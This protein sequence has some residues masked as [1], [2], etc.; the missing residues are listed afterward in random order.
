MTS[1]WSLTAR[2]VLPVD[3]PP[4]EHAVVTIAGD[5]I[6]AVETH[7]TRTADH[8]LG[9]A[10]ILPGLVNAHTHLDLSGARGKTPPGEDFTNWLRVVIDYRQ[11]RTPQEIEADI[12][13]GVTQILRCGTT[14]VGDIAAEGLSWTRL[15]DSPLRSV[16]YYELLG[17]THD[18]AVAATGK[19]IPWMITKR[20]QATA[21]PGLSPHAP[22]SFNWLFLRGV[23]GVGKRI[24]IHL[25]EASA[26][27]E[28]L[29]SQSGPFLRFL[30]ERGVW[31]PEGLVASAQEVVQQT[32]SAKTA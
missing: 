32:R 25:A 30:K 19:A 14:L 27:S 6:V 18:R 26:E 3:A 28:L 20:G 23:A 1:E 11:S 8:D 2:W 17:L 13:D 4:L 12:S 31:D 29:E 21:R 7:G 10:A 9:N 22:Y 15:A 24:A 16:V 5:R